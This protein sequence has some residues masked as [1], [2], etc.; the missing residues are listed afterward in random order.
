M[1]IYMDVAVSGATTIAAGT[2]AGQGLL[3]QTSMTGLAQIQTATF[4]VSGLTAGNNT[5]TLNYA[6][7]NTSTYASRRLIVKG[8]S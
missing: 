4:I 8:I 3:W 1:S 5:F 7:N 2:V 6:N